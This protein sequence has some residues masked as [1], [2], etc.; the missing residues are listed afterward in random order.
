M[1]RQIRIRRLGSDLSGRRNKPS[2][3]F[4][5]RGIVGEWFLIFWNI[6]LNKLERI[7]EGSCKTAC[8][9]V[10]KKL[11]PATVPSK[12]IRTGDK[13]VMSNRVCAV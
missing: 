5:F 12:D 1:K 7:Y 6:G 3:F 13:I 10:F 9:A 2:Q 11:G 8:F 4:M